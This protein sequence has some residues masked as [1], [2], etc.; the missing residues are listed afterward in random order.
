MKELSLKFNRLRQSISLRKL[1]K[2]SSVLLCGIAL[3]YLTTKFAWKGPLIILGMMII[4][5]I[6]FIPEIIL[7]GFLFVDQTP[8][9]SLR[10]EVFLLLS[11]SWIIYV[12]VYKV[13]IVV[14]SIEKVIIGFTFVFILASTITPPFFAIVNI[15]NLIVVYF[16]ITTMLDSEK[17]MKRFIY[18]LI[19]WGLYISL[20]GIM[21]V[22]FQSTIFPTS[23]SHNSGEGAIVVATG[24][25]GDPVVFARTLQFV[26]ILCFYQIL[27]ITEKRSKLILTITLITITLGWLVSG[28][29]STVVSFAVIIAVMLIINRKIS[30]KLI[31]IILLA[32]LFVPGFI[33]IPLL[34]RVHTIIP[35]ILSTAQ[36]Q[37]D[38][39]ISLM[40]SGFRFLFD[41]PIRFVTGV[42]WGNFP[43]Y[44]LPYLTTQL[45]LGQIGGGYTT[46]SLILLLVEGGIIGL[47]LLILAIFWSLLEIMRI[48]KYYKEKENKEMYLI[49][50]GLLIAQIALTVLF[51]LNN[52]IVTY[53]FWLPLALI[54]ALKRITMKGKNGSKSKDE[55]AAY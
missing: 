40:L 22:F 2:I 19:I 34:E 21:Q 43:I 16:V 50:T 45:G 33:V 8:F 13:R 5:F 44:S 12:L 48:R 15:L 9:L 36:P 1:L 42:G 31:I 7:L 4:G 53:L 25:Y 35:T 54:T 37:Q 26:M 41:N 6:F 10:T 18:G 51:L 49:S 39:R 17:R 52:V 3:G 29:R 38:V 55:Q 11:A 14:T 27:A 47:S 32:L 23:F 30:F 20:G 46:S 28:N 24:T